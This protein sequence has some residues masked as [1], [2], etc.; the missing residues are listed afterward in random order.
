MSFNPANLTTAIPDGP[1]QAVHHY[2]TTD[3][4]LTVFSA[5]IRQGDSMLIELSGATWLALV[6]HAYTLGSPSVSIYNA[7]QIA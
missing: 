1:G 6:T 7:I 3:N 4:F 5:G 2:T